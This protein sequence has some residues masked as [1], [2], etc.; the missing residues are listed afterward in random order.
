[1]EVGLSVGCVTGKNLRSEG[2]IHLT[3]PCRERQ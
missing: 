1:L 3:G 2:K